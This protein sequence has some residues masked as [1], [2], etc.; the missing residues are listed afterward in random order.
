VP[1]WQKPGLRVVLVKWRDE[2]T[3]VLERVVNFPKSG[4]FSFASMRR[5]SRC[6]EKLVEEKSGVSFLISPDGRKSAS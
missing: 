6:S 3:G 2:G 4:L 5:I 1:S